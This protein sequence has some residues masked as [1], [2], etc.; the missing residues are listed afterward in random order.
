MTIGVVYASVALP[1]ETGLDRLEQAVSALLNNL[2]SQDTPGVL[3]RLQYEQRE[4]KSD[5]SRHKASGKVLSLPQLPSDLVVG[6]SVVES[7][8]HVWQHL[9]GEDDQAFFQFAARQPDE[10]TS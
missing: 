6:D 3:W 4:Y 9:T 5:I 10:D 2:D 7:V 1:H 8:K